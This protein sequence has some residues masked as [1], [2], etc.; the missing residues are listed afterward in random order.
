MDAIETPITR[1]LGIRC[2]I[3]AAPLSL[4]SNRPLLETVARAGAI[5]LVPAPNFRTHADYRAFLET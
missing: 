2:L 3:V 4:V 5:G 1:M